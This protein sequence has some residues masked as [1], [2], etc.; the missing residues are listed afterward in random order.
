MLKKELLE[1]LKDIPEDGD[2]T[3]TIQNV[4]GLIKPL[5]LNKITIE[6][7]KEILEKNEAIKGYNT[8]VEDGIRS[9]AVEHYKANKGK[10][11][12]ENAVEEALKNAKNEGLSPEQIEVKEL[13]AQLEAMQKQQKLNEVKSNYSN[14]F[15]EKKLD[16]R[17]LDLLNL[18]RESELI[19]K[20]IA[21][22]EEVINSL[23][24]NKVDETF[25]G[26]STEPQGNETT[27]EVLDDVSKAFYAINPNL[28]K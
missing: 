13:K 18:D 8:S 15:A 17:L 20:D 21:T 12:I 25:K 16:T 22:L 27:G 5:D 9:K 6:Q 11:A 14:I 28:G 10:Q 26:S 4:E 1:L 7:Y 3:E 24:S 19:D 2:I 23:V